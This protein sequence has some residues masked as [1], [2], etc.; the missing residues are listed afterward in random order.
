MELLRSWGIEPAEQH[1]F[2]GRDIRLAIT[3]A[4]KEAYEADAVSPD[5]Y[6]VVG[7]VATSHGLP[8]SRE[9][10]EELWHTWNLGGDF[11]GR[12]LFDDAVETLEALRARGYRIACVTNRPFSGPAFLQELDEL[13]LA[14]LFDALSVSCDV[15]YMK[16]HRR[17]FEHALEEIKVLAEEAVMVGDSLR[18]DV[19]ASQ[20]L[21]MIGV[22]RRPP[23]PLDEPDGVRPHFVI[24]DL[25]ELLDLPV[26][27]P[28]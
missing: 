8:T 11:F 2:L 14:P 10:I 20:A 6:A 15:G 19:G 9:K 25:R 16:P 21:G 27:R 7:R 1:H 24:D 3:A 23:R 4:D 22:W 17:I 26:L 5:F 18:A 28:D 12:R 13:G